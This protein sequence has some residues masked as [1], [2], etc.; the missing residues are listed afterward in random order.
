[1]GGLRWDLAQWANDLPGGGF[2]GTVQM[3]LTTAKKLAFATLWMVA[4][5]QQT[6]MGEVPVDRKGD[7]DTAKGFIET[8]QKLMRKFPASLVP[9]KDFGPDGTPDY[10]M[11]NLA[12]VLKQAWVAFG[13][14][15]FQ[16]AKMYEDADK[17]MLDKIWEQFQQ[18]GFND[19]DRVVMLLNTAVS[20]ELALAAAVAWKMDARLPEQLSDEKNAA[21]AVN[22]VEAPKLWKESPLVT[23]DMIDKVVDW[24]KKLPLPNGWEVTEQQARRILVLVGGDTEK[25][26]SLIPTLYGTE[27]DKR[28]AILESGK[29]PFT[30]LP[31]PSLDWIVHWN[32]TTGEPYWMNSDG[33]VTMNNPG[34]L[35]AKRFSSQQNQNAPWKFPLR[36]FIK[37]EGAPGEEVGLTINDVLVNLEAEAAKR[38]EEM[39]ARLAQ[40]S[41]GIASMNLEQAKGLLKLMNADYS[42]IASREESV[43]RAADTALRLRNMTGSNQLP[44]PEQLVEIIETAKAEEAKTKYLANLEGKMKT[45]EATITGPGNVTM[46]IWVNI[47]ELLY[48][49]LTQKAHGVVAQKELIEG[50]TPKKFSDL[51]QMVVVAYPDAHPGKGRF[52]VQVPGDMPHQEQQRHQE[53]GLALINYL[54]AAFDTIKREYPALALVPFPDQNQEEQANVE[55]TNLATNIPT[56]ANTWL[57]LRQDPN[58]PHDFFKLA[59]KATHTQVTQRNRHGQFT[60]GRVHSGVVD[61]SVQGFDSNV[62]RSMQERI[63]LTGIEYNEDRFRAHREAKQGV[64]RGVF[65]FNNPG[66]GQVQKSKWSRRKHIR[67][68]RRHKHI[69]SSRRH[70]HIRSS[71]RHK[72]KRSS[73]RHRHTRHKHIRS[74]RRHK[75]KRSS[76]RHRHTRHKHKRSSRRHTRHKRIRSS[77]TR[78]KHKRSSRRHQAQTE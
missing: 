26:K 44:P 54:K 2:D 36:L 62:P 77:R 72:H 24:T 45:M 32:P 34:N 40:E 46:W 39:A 49:E 12:R 10:N 11:F 71:R 58:L 22:M 65:G 20:P 4:Q 74:S 70:K 6:A 28:R 17:A 41:Q 42:T 51:I 21:Q 33:V 37:S 19:Q 1:M 43:A 38:E 35:L 57:E 50:M 3:G 48:G 8:V 5:I 15:Q 23:Y 53:V 13:A 7:Y 29:D 68:S 67:S 16:G 27:F 30:D 56:I 60:S 25:A 69:R 61:P 31:W 55:A 64:S 73:R 14:A 76:R 9:G 66:G 75:H 18:K 52:L 59:V 63:D 78:H 47:L